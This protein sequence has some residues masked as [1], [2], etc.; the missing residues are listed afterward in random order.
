MSDSWGEFGRPDGIENWSREHVLEFKALAKKFE[1]VKKKKT[2]YARER[3]EKE[4]LHRRDFLIRLANGKTN[5]ARFKKQY[6]KSTEGGQGDATQ[7]GSGHGVT[8]CS[9]QGS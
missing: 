8:G 5:E 4:T 1:E 2:K 7:P 9:D 6:D 3:G